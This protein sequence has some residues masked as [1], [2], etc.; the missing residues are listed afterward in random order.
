MSCV[1]VVADCFGMFEFGSMLWQFSGVP[2]W[3]VY[4]CGEVDLH[5]YHIYLDIRLLIIQ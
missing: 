4:E 3:H 1:F 5:V 2:K